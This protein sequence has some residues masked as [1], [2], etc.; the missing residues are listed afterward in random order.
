MRR[1]RFGICATLILSGL[2]LM[3]PD[4]LTQGSA[5]GSV[6]SWATYRFTPSLPDRQ[7]L[8]VRETMTDGTTR[9]RLEEGPPQTR[10]VFAITYAIVGETAEGLLLQVTT[11]QTAEGPPLS[12][13]QI[14]ISKKDG[15][16]IRSQI[17]GSRGLVVTPENELRPQREN[18]I[19]GPR[20]AV[21]VPAGTY[22]A[23]RG[24]V[25]NAEVWVSDQIPAIG[26]AK[27]VRPDGTL[28]LLK[29]SPTG[30]KDLL[31]GRRT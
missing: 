5:S 25:G 13:T 15:K 28:E 7:Q 31:K 20:E 16:A 19:T 23:V 30:A 4:A 17:L 1:S 14:L 11:H 21:T 29:A 3:A 8:I 10:S 9:I 6:G 26:V 22:Q 18:R 12:T 24:K 27:A 2:V